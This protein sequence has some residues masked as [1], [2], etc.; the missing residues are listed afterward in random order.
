MNEIIG[1]IHCCSFFACEICQPL[2]LILYYLYIDL[3]GGALESSSLKV[4]V[5]EINRWRLLRG[6]R[7][8]MCLRKEGRADD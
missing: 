8:V 4:A 2:Q 1:L 3:T 7:L 5:Q 6:G